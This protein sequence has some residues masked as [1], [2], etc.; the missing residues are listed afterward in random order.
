MELLQDSCDVSGGGGCG[1]HAGSSNKIKPQRVCE[2]VRYS[3][4]FVC[5]SPSSPS[6]LFISTCDC[7]PADQ[8][9]SILKIPADHC[10]LLS[11][12]FGPGPQKMTLMEKWVIFSQTLCGN[13]ALSNPAAAVP[14]IAD[15][16]WRVKIA[17]GELTG[18]FPLLKM[19]TGWQEK[20][21]FSVSLQQGHSVLK[22]V[23]IVFQTL[24]TYKCNWFLQLH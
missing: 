4:L 10:D 12:L 23:R 8:H 5:S 3:F 21:F 13:V 6:A 22:V 17:G 1:H 11:H 15:A 9:L 14:Q 18:H 7:P 19:R 16:A 20:L 2:H 24:I